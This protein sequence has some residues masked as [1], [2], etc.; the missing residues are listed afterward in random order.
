M[1][2]EAEAVEAVGKA[3]VESQPQ[4]VATAFPIEA[5][6]VNLNWISIPINSA[7]AATEVIALKNS[8]SADPVRLVM[9][10]RDCAEVRIVVF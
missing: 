6:R 5:S 10:I 3:K 1:H 7:E 8:R 2:L 4:K 9:Q